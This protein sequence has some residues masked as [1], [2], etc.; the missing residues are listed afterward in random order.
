VPQA[1][2]PLPQT[3]ATSQMSEII[4]LGIAFSL[5]I[6]ASFF[7]GRFLWGL[8]LPISGFALYL[9][10]AALQT[11]LWKFDE[12]LITPLAFSI[13]L[14]FTLG[15]PVVLISILGTTVGIVLSD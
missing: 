2:R 7:S 12:N 4:V 1:A 6:T 3:L 13:A 14:M 15:I 11:N 9:L 5:S 10:V 8:L